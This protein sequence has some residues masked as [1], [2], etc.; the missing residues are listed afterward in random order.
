MGF[1]H[2]LACRKEDVNFRF[3]FLA[4]IIVTL[5]V[6]LLFFLTRSPL[7]CLGHPLR[8]HQEQEAQPPLPGETPGEDYVQVP[9]ALCGPSQVPHGQGGLVPI[10]EHVSLDQ[11]QFPGLRSPRIPQHGREEN[12]RGEARIPGLCSRCTYNFENFLTFLNIPY[13]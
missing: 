2:F 1:R 7:A 12:R 4:F 9:R 13:S 11:R 3:R 10:Q 8:C 6:I 5:I